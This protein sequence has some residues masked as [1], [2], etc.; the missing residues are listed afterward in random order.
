MQESV[1][2]I[3]VRKLQQQLDRVRLA[4]LTAIELGDPRAVA[5]LTCE[6]ARLR[7]SIALAESLRL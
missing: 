7:D 3:D 6:A 1:T 5:R 2:T 4:C